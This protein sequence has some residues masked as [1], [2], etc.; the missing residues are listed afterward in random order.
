VQVAS[1]VRTFAPAPLRSQFSALRGAE[2][3]TI[4]SKTAENSEG[5]CSAPA[6]SSSPVRRRSAHG[7]QRPRS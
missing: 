3:V 2:V 1:S 6:H 7:A 5:M 4:A